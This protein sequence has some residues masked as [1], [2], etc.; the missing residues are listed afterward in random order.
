MEYGESLAQEV[1]VDGDVPVFGSNGVAG[2]HASANTLGPAIIVGRK[3]SFGKVVW[4]DVPGFCIDTAYY[5]DSRHTRENLRW[6]YWA[7]QTLG[8]DVHSED[9][10]VPGLSREKAYQCKLRRP[11]RSEQQRIASFLDEQTARID[12][13]IAEKESLVERLSSY[14]H[15]YSSRLMTLGSATHPKLKQTGFPEVGTIP[16]HWDLKRLKF[17]GEVRSGIAKGKDHGAKETMLLPYLRVANVQDGYV[18]L[19]EVLDIEVGT[20]EIGRYL[21]KAGDVLMNEGGDND[22]LGRGTVWEGQI[23]PCVHQNHV[24]AVRLHDVELAEWVARFTSTAAARSYFFLR[25]KQSTNLASIN[26]TNVRELPVPM[27]PRP[28]R[29]ELLKE[30]RRSATATADLSAHV[31]GHIDRLREYRSSL[32]SAAVTGQLDINNFRAA[33]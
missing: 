29:L 3:G 7:L 33:A 25:S 8:L 12:A 4:T 24:F 1:R 31:T 10:G 11:S 17:L 6:L 28:E 32:I 23:D 19:S 21:L 18:D 15:S 2:A 20:H 16:S 27:P 9:T 5:I 13:L 26:Q 30:L 14:Q 22:K